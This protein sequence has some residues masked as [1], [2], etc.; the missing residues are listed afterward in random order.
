M[1]CVDEGA[2][3]DAGMMTTIVAPLFEL[4][5]CCLICIS[6]PQGKDN[7][8]SRLFFAKNPVTGESMFN[9]YHAKLVCELCEK[10]E[11][12]QICPH[13]KH[14]FPFW[15]NEDKQEI[16]AY[17]MGGRN[18]TFQQESLGLIS[19]LEG[20]LF[21]KRDLED[22]RNKELYF[23]SMHTKCKRVLI[24]MDPNQGGDNETSLFA[25]TYCQGQFLIVGVDSASCK[26]PLEVEYFFKQFIKKLRRHPWLS[27][28]LFMLAVE[29]NTGMVAGSADAWISQ[30]AE[31]DIRYKHRF[32]CLAENTIHTKRTSGFWTSETTKTLYTICA[33]LRLVNR[34]V[35]FIKDW[36]T[37][38]HASVEK[39]M[40][41]ISEAK[42]KTEDNLLEEHRALVKNNF[43][44]QLAN[45]RVVPQKAINP[46]RVSTLKISGKVNAQGKI[47][48]GQN[49]DMALAFT[50]NIG[51]W[52]Y[53][54]LRKLTEV[55]Y[56]EIDVHGFHF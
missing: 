49:D 4:K 13:N 15:K 43:F 55:D 53:L 42:G 39:L 33:Q 11:M 7:P 38:C 12:L 16:T 2:F 22:F 28:A 26:T 21:P 46:S 45:Y 47:V 51:V 29:S 24:S 44:Q 56:D 40:K 14:L 10:K 5:N 1:I 41:T 36:V 17:I 23:Y 20:L 27:N 6:S 34:S 52:E 9:T 48:P 37:G 30:V 8:Y 31:E 3:V 35:S 18:S 50:L 25:T 32:V 54:I 19:D